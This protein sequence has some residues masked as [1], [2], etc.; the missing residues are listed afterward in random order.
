[1][2]EVRPETEHQGSFNFTP[3]ALLSSSR[4]KDIRVTCEMHERD[5]E[6][7]ETGLLLE[8]SLEE[9]MMN[10]LR[11][12]LRSTVTDQQDDLRESVASSLTAQLFIQASHQLRRDRDRARVARH[13]VI[14]VV[15]QRG[16]DNRRLS[17]CDHL[18]DTL[19]LEAIS[20]GGQMGSVHLNAADRE[21]R[22]LRF[23]SE[24]RHLGPRQLLPLIG[25]PFC[26]RIP[27][28]YDM[29]IP[30]STVAAHAQTQPGLRRKTPLAYLTSLTLYCT[31]QSIADNR[32]PSVLYL[33]LVKRQKLRTSKVVNTWKHDVR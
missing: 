8:T 31:M 19:R 24:R 4:L 28:K 11:D 22:H 16:Q 6:H 5:I 26:H 32:Y 33:I 7:G 15:E 20:A 18:S 2:H 3:V 17:H 12:I 14:D 21:N 27:P 23:L 1:M 30:P 13:L 10:E 25:Y 9:R 29:K